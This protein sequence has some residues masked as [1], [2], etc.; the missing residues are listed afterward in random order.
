MRVDRFIFR[1]TAVAFVATVSG[2]SQPTTELKASNNSSQASP[3]PAVR[4]LGKTPVAGANKAAKAQDVRRQA[5]IGIALRI[6]DGKVFI[7]KVLPDS[8][9]ARSNLIKENDQVIAVAEGNVAPIDVTG[10]K[11]VARV[12]GMI[13]GPVRTIVR[14]TMVPKGMDKTDQVVV[15]LMRGDIK[16]IDMFIDG[17]LLPL[18]SK[19]PNFKFTRLGNA[20]NDS[21][22]QLAGRIVVIDFWATWCGPCI[23]ARR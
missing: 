21:L 4:S 7:A 6:A 11:D 20:G 15:S 5:G 8:P 22:F 18:G 19:A 2:C 3:S 1:L 12:V 17:R 13:R 23:K 16:E 9:A 10:T 14:L